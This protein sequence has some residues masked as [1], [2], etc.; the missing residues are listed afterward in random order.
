MTKKI[1][2]AALGKGVVAE[3]LDLIKENVHASAE[4]LKKFGAEIAKD[5]GRNIQRD[6][7]QLRRELRAQIKM[8]GEKSR[9]RLNN[10]T[11][12]YVADKLLSVA[13]VAR[14]ALQL[15]GVKL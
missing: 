4:E 1:D 3:G 8:L 11:W 15:A 13:K 6:S 12:D 7:R 10:A 5:V 2:L 14:V 9:I